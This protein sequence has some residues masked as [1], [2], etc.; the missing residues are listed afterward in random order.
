[1]L[2]WP[3]ARTLQDIDA[4]FG[5]CSHAI[6]TAAPRTLPHMIDVLKK[7]YKTR[8]VHH[9]ILEHTIDFK[10]WLKPHSDTSLGNLKDSHEIR[11]AMA[12]YNGLVSNP[13]QIRGSSL[14]PSYD[15]RPLP[16]LQGKPVAS[17]DIHYM[18]AMGVKPLK[19]H[20]S[21]TVATVTGHHT[22]HATNGM[23]PTDTDTLMLKEVRPLFCA[24]QP[25]K[26]VFEF[27]DDGTPAFEQDGRT[28]KVKFVDVSA[29]DMDC[30]ENLRALDKLKG[31]ITE[32]HQSKKFF[33]TDLQQ[34]PEHTTDNMVSWWQDFDRTQRDIMMDPQKRCRQPLTPTSDSRLF[35]AFNTVVLTH[36]MDD[37]ARNDWLTRQCA[38]ARRSR[39]DD[40]VRDSEYGVEGLLRQYTCPTTS[41]LEVAEYDDLRKMLE[42][43]LPETPATRKQKPFLVL[44]CGT[45][46]KAIDDWAGYF[47][48]GKKAADKKHPLLWAWVC[49]VQE[50]LEHSADWTT[51]K[52]RVHWYRP[53]YKARKQW[54]C[55][56]WTRGSTIDNKT[57]VWDVDEPNDPAYWYME[58]YTIHINQVIAQFDAW[59][60]K[61]VPEKD[62]NQ[63]TI[64]LANGTVKKTTGC[65]LKDYMQAHCERRCL[66]LHQSHLEG[67]GEDL[68]SRHWVAAEKAMA[69]ETHTKS[70]L[71]AALAMEQRAHGLADLALHLINDGSSEQGATSGGPTSS[72]EVGRVAATSRTAGRAGASRARGRSQPD[73]D[74]PTP[75]F[76]AGKYP[77]QPLKRK[78]GNAARNGRVPQRQRL[79]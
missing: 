29:E 50:V 75:E 14:L 22:Q 31:I 19:S 40:L 17:D 48:P 23:A 62:D 56:F 9:F 15:M 71:T 63:N 36:N 12:P 25:K 55:G 13:D 38:A 20:P 21:F 57:V 65:F 39:M 18:P 33:Y 8:D 42:G 28:P 41:T 51:A 53:A 32:L 34:Y 77:K 26:K 7:T 2:T 3:V 24:H 6:R 35:S 11:I 73:P 43:V 4:I 52:L 54:V 49:E 78:N 59:Y 30:R 72:S 60:E 74:E 66:E 58:D 5:V 47:G 69:G 16:V 46:P 27:N 10:S 70:T 45:D 67:D 68:A 79:R 44:S 61:S 1:M 76:T 64:R 37:A